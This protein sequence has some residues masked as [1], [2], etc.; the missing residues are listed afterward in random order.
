M[1]AKISLRP[2]GVRTPSARS[3]VLAGIHTHLEGFLIWIKNK[4]VTAI[5]SQDRSKGKNS[6]LPLPFGPKRDNGQPF[7]WHDIFERSRG[8]KNSQR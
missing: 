3:E 2:K 4:K 7:S 5:Q 6:G 8:D 1:P